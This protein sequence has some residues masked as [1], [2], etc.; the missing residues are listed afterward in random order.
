[1]IGWVQGS[2][3]T[4]TDDHRDRVQVTWPPPPY[5]LEASGTYTTL[6]GGPV[7]VD[8]AWQKPQDLWTG[9]EASDVSRYRIL[10]GSS[11]KTLTSQG[12][13]SGL[14]WQGLIDT[15]DT[16]HY[17]VAGVSGTATSLRSLTAKVGPGTAPSTPPPTGTRPSV[18]TP[19]LTALVQVNV[20]RHPGVEYKIIGHLEPNETVNL[21]AHNGKP[22]DQPAGTGRWWLIELDDEWGWVAHLSID[23]NTTLVT[24]TRENLVSGTYLE[25]GA[26]GGGG[27]VYIDPVQVP[28]SGGALYARQ[29]LAAGSNPLRR[30][31]AAAAPALATG[32]QAEVWYTVRRLFARTGLGDLWLEV[33]P[34]SAIPSGTAS[35][36]AGWVPAAR[37]VLA[38]QG[39][40]MLPPSARFVRLRAWVTAGANVRPGPGPAYDPPLRSLPPDGVWY[41][42]AGKNT[43]PPGWWRIQVSTNVY[44]WVHG[45]LVDL[46]ATETVPVCEPPE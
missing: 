14:R 28:P 39:T 21:L 5:R 22:K 13:T 8:L 10:R 46:K 45:S 35:G 23:G 19:Q 7:R 3:V 38:A 44:G 9:A 37:M 27:Q 31:P 34:H 18:A 30:W 41:P 11:P 4:V 26:L 1:M 17:A 25:D 42:V 6:S 2:A 24:V 33:Q 16:F 12:P 36:A 20:R 29:G 32:V 43:E 15:Q 40:P